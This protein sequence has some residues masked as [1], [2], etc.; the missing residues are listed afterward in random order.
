MKTSSFKG[1]RLRFGGYKVQGVG[2][3][4]EEKLQILRYGILGLGVKDFTIQELLDV[5]F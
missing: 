1:V 4:V 2:F 3:Q 5:S